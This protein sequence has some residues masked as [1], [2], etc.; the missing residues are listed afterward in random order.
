MQFVEFSDLESRTLFS[1]TVGEEPRPNPTP[2]PTPS[3]INLD[4]DR[5]K[6]MS[7]VTKFKSDVEYV[8]GV[9]TAARQTRLTHAAAL[10]AQ[11]K[12]LAAQTHTDELSQKTIATTGEASG[13]AVRAKW[14]AIISPE[15]LDV[16]TNTEG[17]TEEER[18]ADRAKLESDRAAAKAELAG[19][20]AATKASM[21]TLQATLKADRAAVEAAKRAGAAQ[22]KVDQAAV[23]LAESK[24]RSV[25]QADHLI[26]EADL[27][28][29]RAHGGKMT[30]LT[31]PVMPK[32]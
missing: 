14:A 9:L 3:P 29:Y 31:L 15:E 10:D 23:T 30:D 2:A 17:E 13:R 32:L 1:G 18:V 4:S 19:V 16:R 24:L 5:A 8:R 21:D 28:L 27:R 26:V 6:I 7:D 25:F 20:Q 11:V 22:L 12:L